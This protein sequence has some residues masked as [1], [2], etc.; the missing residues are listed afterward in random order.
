MAVTIPPLKIPSAILADRNRQGLD[1]YAMEVYE[2][3]S[4]VRLESPRVKVDDSIDPYL[5]SYVVPGSSSEIEQGRLCKISWQG[6]IPPSWAVNILA[7][8][9]TTLPPKEWF[10]ICTTPFT[11]VAM[12]HGADCTIMRPP[13][14]AG[15]YVLWEVRGHE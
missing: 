6:F 3:L 5:S 9:I 11:R 12:G 4:L 10:T 2:W 1:E 14:S 8:L 13:S 15:E 7:A